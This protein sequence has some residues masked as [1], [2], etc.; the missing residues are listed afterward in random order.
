MTNEEIRELLNYCSNTME[1]VRAT[2]APNNT[3]AR[4]VH[5]SGDTWVEV[6][7]GRAASSHA[8]LTSARERIRKALIALL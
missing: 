8:Q 7:A 2:V 5:E 6:H 3:A 1:Y 4:H